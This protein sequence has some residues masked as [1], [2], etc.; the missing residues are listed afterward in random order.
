MKRLIRHYMV[1]WSGYWLDILSYNVCN[2]DNLVKPISILKHN[3]QNFAINFVIKRA[4]THWKGF[5][6]C[7]ITESDIFSLYVTLVGTV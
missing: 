1:W 6:C 5:P 7:K 4:S 2:C 3:V